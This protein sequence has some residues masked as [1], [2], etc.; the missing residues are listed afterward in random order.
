MNSFELRQHRRT[1]WGMYTV[2]YGGSVSKTQLDWLDRELSRGRAAG[3]DVVVL[4]HH[5]PRG[6]HGGK[7]FGY[8]SPMLTFAGIAQSTINYLIAEKLVPAVCKKPDWSLSVDDR[9]SCLHD[10]LQEWMGPDDPFDKEGASY[11]MSGIELLKR[12][13]KAPEVRTMLLGHVHYNSLEVLR[14]GDSLV[15]DRLALDP[16]TAARNASIEAQN[17]I[18]RYAWEQTL[19]APLDLHS[20]DAWRK[21]LD[22]LLARPPSARAKLP[23]KGLDAVMAPAKGESRELAIVRFTSGAD[24]TPQTYSGDAMYG[25]SVFHVTKQTDVPRINRVGFFI[26]RGGAAFEKVETIDIDRTRSVTAR[27]PVNPVERL[28]DR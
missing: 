14:D 22:G 24:L 4:M 5:D 23:M 26:H 7:D 1:G 27:D 6:G 3:E 17:P 9:N 10:G 25:F 12:I 16:A 2:N 18:R 8:Y 20:W 15:P 21:E 11:F 13:S 19:G 28:F